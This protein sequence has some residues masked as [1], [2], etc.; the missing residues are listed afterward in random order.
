MH[1][2][3]IFDFVCP[4][5]FVGFT[6]DLMQ[7]EYSAG[8]RH[9][10]VV[11]LVN[12]KSTI[13]SAQLHAFSMSLFI[14]KLPLQSLS[15]ICIER[16]SFLSSLKFGFLG[17]PLVSCAILSFIDPERVGFGEIF[18]EVISRGL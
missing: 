9:V 15:N 11:D 2:F 18:A 17:L 1:D 6:C 5:Q 10:R 4:K 14:V 12:L 16:R 3:R 7:S 13:S 8:F